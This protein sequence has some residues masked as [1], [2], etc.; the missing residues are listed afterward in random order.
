MTHFIRSNDLFKSEISARMECNN[1]TKSLAWKRRVQFQPGHESN[2]IWF[3]HITWMLDQK[4]FLLFIP[5]CSGQPFH[6]FPSL[7]CLPFFQC[8]STF[9]CGRWWC[10]CTKTYYPHEKLSSLLF[11]LIIIKFLFYRSC[12]C[13]RCCSPRRLPFI[14][15]F[16]HSLRC[17]W[18][19][20]SSHDAL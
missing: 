19:R 3:V 11:E 15:S 10:V 14:H 1:P 2:N 9:P 4:S 5:H 13:C 7:S 20:F 17:L 16:I 8:L 18:K 12:S 6:F